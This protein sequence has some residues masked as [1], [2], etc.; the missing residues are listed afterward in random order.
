MSPDSF[1]TELLALALA[2]VSAAGLGLLWGA[3]RGHARMAVRAAA[4]LACLLTA[5]ATA[6]VWVN[7]QVDAYPTWSSLAGSGNAADSVATP[8]DPAGAGR[9]VSM[10]VPGKVSGLSL[11]LYVYLPA[12]YAKQPGT[13]FPV[14]EALHGYPGTPLQWFHKMHVAAV[15]DSEMA[16]ARMAPTVVVFPYQTPDTMLDTECTN[17]VNGPQTET[18][19][20]VDVPA[21]VRARFHVRTDAAGW[22]LAGYSAGGYCATDLLLRHPGEYAAAASLSGYATPGIRVGDGSENTLYNDVWRLK[23]LPVPAVALYLACARTDLAPLHSTVALARAARAPLSV[24]T[25]Y[26]GGG[27]HNSATWQALEAPAFDWLSASLGRPVPQ[28]GRTPGSTPA[29]RA[30]GG[31]GQPVGAAA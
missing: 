31:P 23:H 1:T 26:V 22:G 9:I 14:V 25:S 15:L 16:A 3:G 11:P 2:V 27:G 24:T 10:T 13:R 21:A 29:V 8:A 7:R 6:A 17:L 4:V 30:A 19:L 20:T 5:S 12:A 18:L 28:A